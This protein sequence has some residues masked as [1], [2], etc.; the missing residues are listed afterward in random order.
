MLLRIINYFEPNSPVISPRDPPP[1]FIAGQSLVGQGLLTIEA[2]RSQSV[3][4]TAFGNSSGRVISPT[5]RPIPSTQYSQ[6]TD[7]HAP[8]GIRTHNPSK[9]AANPIGTLRSLVSI[10]FLRLYDYYYFRNLFSG[11]LY[12][13]TT[14]L[15]F[16]RVPLLWLLL[17]FVICFEANYILLRW[18][19]SRLYFMFR[20]Y[21]ISHSEYRN[22]CWL[23]CWN[24]HISTSSW[25]C[26]NR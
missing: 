8:G 20:P 22:W 9:R 18:L 15:A 3:A 26:E 6:E 21:E 24:L 25:S 11:W 14:L 13:T 4:H 17:C 7:I 5:H 2:S 10:I 16:T 19:R 12:F 23:S 1:P